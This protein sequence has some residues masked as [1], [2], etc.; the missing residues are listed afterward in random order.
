[1]SARMKDDKRLRDDKEK[2]VVMVQIKYC[3]YP[4]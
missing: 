4:V 3:E 2:N 1:M